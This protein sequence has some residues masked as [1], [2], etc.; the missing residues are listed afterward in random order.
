MNTSINSKTIRDI[1]T[2]KE[3]DIPGLIE[4]SASVGWER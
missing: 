1:Y 4:L 3:R 2:F